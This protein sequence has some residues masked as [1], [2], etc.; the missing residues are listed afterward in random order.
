MEKPVT[1]L[2]AQVGVG[3]GEDEAV[4]RVALSSEFC[5][6]ISKLI[7]ADARVAGCPPYLDC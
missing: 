2:G 3:P 4:G 5:G 1:D 7:A 6:S